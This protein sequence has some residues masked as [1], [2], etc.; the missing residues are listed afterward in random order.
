MKKVSFFIALLTLVS[1]SKVKPPEPFGPV[2]SE[3]QLA[4]HEMEFYAFVHFNMNTFT[5]KEWGFGDESPELFPIMGMVIIALSIV[6]YNRSV[7]GK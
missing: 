4:W 5:D 3:R 6:I 2:P 7:S 1:C